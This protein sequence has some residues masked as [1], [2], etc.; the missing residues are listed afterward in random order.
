MHLELRISSTILKPAQMVSNTEVTPVALR[1]VNQESKADLRLRE[2]T[3]L[4]WLTSFQ[5]KLKLLA[6]LDCSHL[7]S[8][9]LT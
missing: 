9:D 3:Q 4:T 2:A 7:N 1:K 6:M 5:I 8:R